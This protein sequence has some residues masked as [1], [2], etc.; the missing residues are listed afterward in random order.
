MRGAVRRVGAGYERVRG[1]A[2]RGLRRAFLALGSAP[3]ARTASADL[4]RDQPGCDSRLSSN[5]AAIRSSSTLPCTSPPTTTGTTSALSAPSRSATRGDRHRRL[6]EPDLPERQIV[7]RQTRRPRARPRATA[8][9]PAT[10]RTTRPPR[11][12]STTGEDD[13]G[14]RQARAQPDDRPQNV[15]E[16]AS[17]P[18]ARPAASASAAPPI[19][20]GPLAPLRAQLHPADWPVTNRRVAATKA[21]PS[22][23][24]SPATR[25][26]TDGQPGAHTARAAGPTVDP[27]AVARAY[28]LERAKAV[29]ARAARPRAQPRHLRWLV[30][31]LLTSALPAARL[32]RLERGRAAL[33]LVASSS[34]ASQA[35]RGRKS[36]G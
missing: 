24:T 30:L 16:P 11:S 28:R 31:V 4:R 10:A 3:N 15:S 17:P 13:I 22:A 14:A 1:D 25:L 29:R 8:E 35:L 32:L 27:S 21:A 19:E 20:S 23:S 2:K 12:A 36:P 9:E 34:R 7:E 18:A 26:P 6:A 5:G 33:R